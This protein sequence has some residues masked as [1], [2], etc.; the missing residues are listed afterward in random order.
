MH[1]R[2]SLP[3]KAQSLMLRSGVPVG[4]VTHMCVI[5]F[6]YD[7][8]HILH[9]RMYACI[10]TCANIHV[11]PS[12]YVYTNTYIHTDTFVGV[13]KYVFIYIYM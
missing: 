8:K 4:S 1:L 3:E 11:N 7:Y 6:M 2:R 13:Y 9:V 5:I 10:C 12:M